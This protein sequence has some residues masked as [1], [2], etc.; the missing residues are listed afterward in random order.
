MTILKQRVV[1]AVQPTGILTLGNFLGAIKNWIKLQ[2][3]FDCI[4]GIADLHS[5][6]ISRDPELLKKNIL[7]TFAL[8]I[9]SG[10]DVN[11]CIFFLQS[12]VPQHAELA[13]ILNCHTSVGELFRMIQFK[14]KSKKNTDETN[15]GILT[16]PILMSADVL[17]YQTD[18]VS[19]GKDQEQHI[20]ICRKIAR[21]FNK[22]FNYKF[23]IPE[24]IKTN[25]GGKIM[26]LQDPNR[27]MSKSDSNLMSTIYLLD[28]KE[29][30]FK[31]IKRAVTDNDGKIK[32]SPSKP[33]I[34]NLLNIFC[35]I[36][37]I[38]QEN[39]EILFQNTKYSEF[40]TILSQEIFDLLKII[41]EKYREIREDEKKLLDLVHDQSKKAEDIAKKNITNIKNKVG[42]VT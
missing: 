14:E 6:T 26:S 35:S 8:L 4:F 42:L 34:T 17:L 10:L 36:K 3:K 16:Y 2:D 20:E 23:K 7:D 37:N 41:Q 11:K 18:L 38:S 12:C 27:K 19:V 22:K 25:F 9:A 28:N 24:V 5:L 33:A 1:S 29:L 39:A 32:F 31:K 15:A 30:I 21:N 13:W 40:K